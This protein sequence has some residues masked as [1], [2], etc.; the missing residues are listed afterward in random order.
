MYLIFLLLELVDVLWIDLALV[1]P[2]S[3]D[4]RFLQSVQSHLLACQLVD[5]RGWNKKSQEE[6]G[7]SNQ[8]H[9][10]TDSNQLKLD[11]GVAG[12][13]VAGSENHGEDDCE[14]HQEEKHSVE[15]EEEHSVLQVGGDHQPEHDEDH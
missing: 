10:S 14:E 12:G 8:L 9:T 15:G 6:C 3:L 11:T 1:F 7:H 2:D 4:Q 13:E 5:Q